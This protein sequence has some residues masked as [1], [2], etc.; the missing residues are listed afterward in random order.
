M[1]KHILNLFLLCTLIL[2][3]QSAKIK[4]NDASK[5]LNSK[6]SLDH[7]NSSLYLLPSPT[8]RTST[9]SYII[10]PLT[11]VYSSLPSDLY[12]SHTFVPKSKR[13]RALL[14]TSATPEAI[15]TPSNSLYETVKPLNEKNS[16][17]VI[18]SSS[19]RVISNAPNTKIPGEKVINAI[20]ANVPQSNVQATEINNSN[21]SLQTTL[22]SASINSST[23]T[24]AETTS[25]TPTFTTTNTDSKSTMPPEASFTQASLLNTENSSPVPSVSY[26]GNS[27][28]HYT[29]P[30]DQ[31]ILNSAILEG[32]PSKSFTLHRPTPH[33]HRKMHAN[34]NKFISNAIS[35]PIQSIGSNAPIRAAQINS[36]SSL[37]SS[38]I[39]SILK[40]PQQIQQQISSSIGEK[41][42]TTTD[43]VA[44][45][46]DTS[47]DASKTLALNDTQTTVMV[48]AKE[49]TNPEAHIRPCY[50]RGRKVEFSQYW[51]PKENEW[52]ETNR[53]KRV[54]L[55]GDA[56]MKL[57]D[58]N[59]Q[60]IGVVPVDM[61]QK[62][63]MEGTVSVS[64]II[65]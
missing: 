64:T 3:A 43:F 39:P 42:A 46:I 59:D 47:L 2:Q 38:I 18:D 41:A 37:L 7:K 34:K 40:Q 5:I 30:T 54:F 16:S 21:P 27:I 20:S 10:K 32:R 36:Q 51:I 9:L 35:T 12:T 48:V 60:E 50:R 45:N 31:P 13:K 28:E 55:G 65:I 57:Y 14:E 6:E 62:C 56:K 23:E 17:A 25:N 33:S 26:A 63:R 58:R 4:Q 29:I 15:P 52:D 53:G 49:V 24:V 11:T 22:A 1:V 19:V 61:Y 44:Q 8:A